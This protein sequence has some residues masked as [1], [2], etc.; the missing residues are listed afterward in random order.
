MK[1]ADG[2]FPWL[3][4]IRKLTWFTDGNAFHNAF[5][6]A[7]SKERLSENGDNLYPATPVEIS[8]FGMTL[9]MWR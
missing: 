1:A 7:V 6:E 2:N 5:D 3:S 4:E 8:N 9:Q